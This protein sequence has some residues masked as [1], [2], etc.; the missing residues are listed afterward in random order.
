MLQVRAGK[1]K[2]FSV[3]RR[4]GLYPVGGIGSDAV[5]RINANHIYG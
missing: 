3:C 5:A 4:F 2:T 1:L